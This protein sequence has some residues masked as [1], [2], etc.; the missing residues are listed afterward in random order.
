MAYK[1]EETRKVH[2][3]GLNVVITYQ[4][5][6]V[7]PCCSLWDKPSVYDFQE[8]R[9]II[10]ISNS[11]EIFLGK[12]NGIG[13]NF[14]KGYILTSYTLH[15]ANCKNETSSELLCNPLFHCSFYCA[16][17]IARIIV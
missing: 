12:L 5:G 7:N 3:K 11:T 14:L 16:Y 9:R 2:G 17:L 1:E 8:N 15:I 4:H 6:A 10:L 13:S